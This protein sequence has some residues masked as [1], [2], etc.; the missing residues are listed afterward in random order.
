MCL[1]GEKAC[2]KVLY[3]SM[4]MKEEYRVSV[5]LTPNGRLK[6]A[7]KDAGVKDL[8]MITHLKIAGAFTDKDEEYLVKNFGENLQEVDFSNCIELSTFMRNC[9][10]R[11][12]I[13]VLKEK[14]S[15]LPIQKYIEDT[16]QSKRKHLDTK[17]AL[18]RGDKCRE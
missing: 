13:H 1:A 15:F 18:K 4:M 3:V 12:N 16:L 10:L 7:L 8:A 9:F 11:K 17:R 6:Q 14:H 5:V 2:E